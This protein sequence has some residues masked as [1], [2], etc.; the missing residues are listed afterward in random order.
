MRTALSRACG[1]AALAA[2]AT[3]FTAGTAAAHITA[4]APGAT[5][6]GYAF[7]TFRVPNESP[8]DATTEVTV[9]VPNLRS[10]YTQPVPG[11][12][13]RVDR[14]DKNEIVAVTWTAEPGAPG[15]AD[16]QFQGFTVAFGPMPQQERVE[17]PAKQVYS[18]GKVVD[19][20]QSD[21]DGKLVPAPAPS[22]TLAAGSGEHSDGHGVD[23][24]AADTDA[25]ADESDDIARWL[26]GAGLALGLFAVALGLGNLIRRRS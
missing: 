9:T 12:S 25:A 3:L 20:N 24:S 23:A 5:Q 8:T 18:D 14:N 16:G 4:D 21:A 2:T 1:A 22:I 15:I 7:V 17:F 19:W 10:A 11:W 6:G 26:G 13:A